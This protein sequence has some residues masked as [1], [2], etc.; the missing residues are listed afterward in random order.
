[1]FLFCCKKC[2]FMSSAYHTCSVTMFACGD[3]HPFPKYRG[4]SAWTDSIIICPWSIL[5]KSNT[6]DVSA[7]IIFFLKRLACSTP[8]TTKYD[9]ESF[10]RFYLLSVL[11]IFS[12]EDLKRHCFPMMRK[13]IN[14]FHV[15]N[16][17]LTLTRLRIIV[18]LSIIHIRLYHKSVESSDV[19]MFKYT[20]Y[21]IAS[22]L[23]SSMHAGVQ[24]P[25]WFIIN[26]LNFGPQ[27][28]HWRIS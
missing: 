7:F 21:P 16:K 26:L 2:P 13:C 6:C 12:S 27:G 19:W 5:I 24:S 23:W 22:S 18:E 14:N 28:S 17:Y 10:C 20:L 15:M 25:W 4:C 8:L 1:M 3:I 9:L 11:I